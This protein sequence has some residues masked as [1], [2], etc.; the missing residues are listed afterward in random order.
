MDTS[1]RARLGATLRGLPAALNAPDLLFKGLGL[2]RAL[3]LAQIPWHR[4]ATKV[5][6]HGRDRAE[7]VTFIDAQGLP[8]SVAVDLVLL[9]DGVIPNDQVMRQLGCAPWCWSTT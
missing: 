1:P 4:H 5:S 8:Q 7:G 2:H 6:I 3:K 9:H